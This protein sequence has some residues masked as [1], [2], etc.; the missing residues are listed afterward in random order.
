MTA[1]ITYIAVYVLGVAAGILFA[2][3]AKGVEYEDF[4]WLQEREYPYKDDP[5]IPSK[6]HTVTGSGSHFMF[7]ILKK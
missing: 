5:K 6:Q 2:L 4:P 3:V 7:G 1:E